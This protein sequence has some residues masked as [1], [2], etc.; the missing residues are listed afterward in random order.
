MILKDALTLA[1][2]FAMVVASMVF[3]LIVVG[4]GGCVQ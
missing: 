2:A 4:P 1:M 3:V